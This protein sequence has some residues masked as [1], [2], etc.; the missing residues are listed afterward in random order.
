VDLIDHA[1]EN[2]GFRL[3]YQPIVSLQGDTRENYSALLR[4]VDQNGE[5]QR[6]ESFWS[7]ARN[8]NRLAEI[9]RWVVRNAIMELVKHRH[10]GKKINFHIML[11]HDGINDDSMLLWVCD[12]LREFKAKGAWLCFQFDE[13]DLRNNPQ[14]AR[15]LMD[16]LKKINCKVAINN[17]S[18]GPSSDTLLQ[19]LPVDI[20]KLSHDFMS[21]LA[22]DARRQDTLREINRQL[23]DK[24]LN[25]IASGVEDANSLAVLWNV[26]VNYIQGYFLQEPARTIAFNEE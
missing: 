11:S 15:T 16:G 12:C 14:T 19:H 26:G 22:N 5:E 8:A 13:T 4:L 6:P 9:D 21:N 17:F 20:V 10:E 7:H 1:L 25:T 23:Q 24:G 2:D 18:N 3:V